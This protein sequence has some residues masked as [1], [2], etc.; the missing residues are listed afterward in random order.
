MGPGSLLAWKRL[1]SFLFFESL[2]NLGLD[3][4][5][6]FVRLLR[7]D[8]AGQLHSNYHIGLQDVVLREAEHDWSARHQHHTHS[9]SQ[10][11]THDQFD[12][13]GILLSSNQTKSQTKTTD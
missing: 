13:P 7:V 5:Q 2:P 3:S 11:P 1:I 4:V 6:P 12:Y 8:D 9:G 10:P